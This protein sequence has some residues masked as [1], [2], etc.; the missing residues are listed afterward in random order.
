MA[1]IQLGGGVTD[2][3]GSIGGSTFARN[4][5]G[6]YIRA[7]R[8]PVNPMS[9]RQVARRTAL[10][11][12][13]TYWSKTLTAQQRADWRAYAAGTTWTNRLGQVIEINGL[14]AFLRL[15]A[16]ERL[17]PNAPH[18]A[19]PTAMGHAGGVTAT[20]AAESDTTK[21]QLDEPTGAFDKSTDDDVLFLFQ[22]LP[23]EAGRQ[24]H[25]SGFRYIGVCEGDSMTPPTFP[26]EFTSAYTMA[27]GQLVTLRLMFH[28]ASFRV[29]GPT[30]Q[31][32]T[33]A[34]A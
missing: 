28:D 15:N 9:T 10:A 18:A 24:M 12:L 25:P 30:W 31:T 23:Q 4:A 2:I 22:G 29:A 11:W 8:K 21:I 6:N 26:L 32:A 5:G 27:A 19:A 17:V 34:P 16:L 7:R 1:V 14:A 33:A 20:F 3:R 13:T